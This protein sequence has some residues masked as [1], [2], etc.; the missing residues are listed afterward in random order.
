MREATG[1]ATLLV[2]WDDGSH[3]T[4]TTR[5]LRLEDLA[6]G[7]Q[8]LSPGP[9]VGARAD[10][11]GDVDHARDG[12]DADSEYDADDLQEGGDDSELDDDDDD[13]FDPENNEEGEGD[14]H[15]GGVDGGVPPVTKR[16]P[17][18]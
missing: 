3:S 2:D 12:N 9:A 10:A 5:E 18:G 7:R 11:D 14:R 8:L 15:G 13:F 16:P 17:S 1:L 6:S 4:I